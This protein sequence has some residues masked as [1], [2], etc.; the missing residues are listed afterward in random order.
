MGGRA[1]FLGYRLGSFLKWQPGEA[2]YLPSSSWVCVWLLLPDSCPKLPNQQSPRPH[3]IS[4]GS[5]LGSFM[6][7]AS[8]KSPTPPQHLSERLSSDAAQASSWVLWGTTTEDNWHP[9]GKL[10]I[11]LALPRHTL[12]TPLDVEQNIIAA[13]YW[14]CT[15]KTTILWAC[16][17]YQQNRPGPLPNGFSLLMK[18]S[19][20]VPYFLGNTK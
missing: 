13:L 3:R 6:L 19:W 15:T 10:P 11:A 20:T 9:Q 8:R 17:M 1:A 7:S 12:D 5:Q 18:S 4:A 2:P 16:S 14:F